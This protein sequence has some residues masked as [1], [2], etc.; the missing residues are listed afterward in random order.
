M[1]W[2]RGTAWV[3]LLLLRLLRRQIALHAALR[4][5]RQ[6]ARLVGHL[7]GVVNQCRIEVAMTGR[8]MAEQERQRRGD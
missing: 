2:P 6:A 7:R 8:A 4:E 3:G 1:R 5:A